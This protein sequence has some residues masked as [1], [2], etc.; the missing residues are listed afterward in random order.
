[1]GI[2]KFFKRNEDTEGNILA[3][4]QSVRDFGRACRFGQSGALREH[5]ELVFV[6]RPLVRIVFARR[7]KPIKCSGRWEYPIWIGTL[8]QKIDVG[9]KRIGSRS[10]MSSY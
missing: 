7:K 6:S 3:I 4:I 1:M 2:S 9:S 10:L 8:F 5:S